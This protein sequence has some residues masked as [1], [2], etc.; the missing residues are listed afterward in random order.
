MI[1]SSMEHKIS[2]FCPYDETEWV[3]NNTG[4]HG[5]SLYRPKN[6]ETFSKYLFCV[7]PVE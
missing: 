1:F 2:G 7:C 4:R 6:K 5:H 3:Q